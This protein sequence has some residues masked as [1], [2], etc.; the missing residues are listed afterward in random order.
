VYQSA[1]G[2][3][4]G[5]AIYDR[6]LMLSSDRIVGPAIV[7][8]PSSTTVIHSGDVLTVGDYGELVIE[9]GASQ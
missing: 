7:E 2:E 5:Y 6:G 1:L 4:V 8:E 3:R 9:I